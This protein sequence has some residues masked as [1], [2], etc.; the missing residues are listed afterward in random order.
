LLVSRVARIWATVES[1]ASWWSEAARSVRARPTPGL[2]VSRL[3]GA[4]VPARLAQA[5][6]LAAMAMQ[7]RAVRQ[8]RAVEVA[9]Q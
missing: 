4:P 3:S 5:L 6:R 2:L 1:P 9:R 8:W 7:V